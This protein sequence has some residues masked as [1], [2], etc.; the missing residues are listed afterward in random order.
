MRVI[1]GVDGSAGGLEAV[2]Q[3]SQLLDAGKDQVALYYAPPSIKLKSSTHVSEEVRQQAGQSL[4]KAVFEQSDA[5][6]PAELIV[7]R[8]KVVGSQKPSHGLLVAAE[9]WRAD[10]IAVGARG[11]G[12][13]AN[14]LLGSVSR[15]VAEAATLPV[16]VVRAP[17][18][19]R[20]GA[21]LRVL[22]AIDDQTPLDQIAA[23]LKRLTWPAQAVGKVVTVIESMFAGEIPQWLAE[24]ARDAETEAMAQAW[25]AE[26]E[27]ER[28]QAAAKLA[29]LRTK[30][31]APF[32]SAEPIVAEGNPAEQILATAAAEGA[33]LLVVGARNSGR[34][35][36]LLM[37]S[38]SHKV[39]A[40]A[41]C[42]VLIVHHHE[43]P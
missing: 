4:A 27:Q 28:R 5:A 33:D 21:G 7:G 26:H 18:A 10:L 8:E 41:P 42:S 30:L 1:V 38:T 24:K 15:T 39:L 43:K 17:S 14:L 13:V 20:A 9:G 34:I 6:L 37:G 32:Q 3:V 12:P 16:L 40:H 2:R 19:P 29:A 36:R 11:L 25:V 23:L 31:P 35:S 22:L